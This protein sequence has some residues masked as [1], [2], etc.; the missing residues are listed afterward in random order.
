MISTV[1]QQRRLFRRFGWSWTVLAMFIAGCSLIGGQDFLPQPSGEAGRDT[2][3]SPDLPSATPTSFP[4][5][6]APPRVLTVCLANE[7]ETLY[8]YGGAS[9]A[10]K[11][12]LEAI[13]DGP[14]D[15]VGYQF[16]PVILEQLPN[17]ADGNAALEPSPVKAG[18]WVV[19]DAGE[20]VQLVPGEV[21]RPSGCAAP[22]CAVAWDGNPLVMD[23]LSATFTIKEGILWSDGAPLTAADSVFSYELARQCRIEGRPCGGLGLVTQDHGTVERTASYTALDDRRVQWTG[24]PGFRDPNY[25]VNFFT[26]LPAHLLGAQPPETLLIG[27]TSARLPPGWGPYLVEN[28][29]PGEAIRLRSNPLYFRA[30]EGLPAFDILILRFFSGQTEP[31]ENAVL[32]GSCDLLDQAAG[33]TFLVEDPARLLDLDQA[34]SIRAHFAAGPVW[35]QADFGLRPASYDDGYQPATDRPDLFGDP[36]T[37]QGIA[38]CMDRQRITTEV[39]N[40]IASVPAS[41]YP[42]GHPLLNPD[43]PVILHDPAAGADLLAQAGWIDADGDPTTPRTA[44]GVAGVPDG[45]LLAFSYLVSDAIQ[46]LAAATILTESLAECGVAVDLQSG[47][48]GEVYA[49]GPD[50]PVF[51]RR[52]DMAQFAWE[53]SIQSACYLWSSQQIPGDPNLT[54]EDGRALFPFGWGGANASGF[55]DPEFDRACRASRE[56]LPGEP[57]YV[58]THHRAQELFAAALPAIPLYEHLRVVVSRPDLCNFTFDPSSLSE[59][60]NIEELDFREE[61]RE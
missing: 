41:F 37:R 33:Q 21:I 40:G 57:G 47:P 51:G 28:W 48:A 1:S 39:L 5:P 59:F 18:D 36:R 54:A 6:T 38:L 44:L 58:E 42:P 34:G 55:A 24:V 3:L 8:L 9:L 50:G 2:P 11:Q 4:T 31:L 17:L 22:E 46:R 12:V 60:W 23:R 26:P 10:Q 13:Y 56:A 45:T 30:G 14:I 27:E 61:C 52:F 35:E 16:Q 7:P 29:V 20:L 43:L 53:S 15:R 32:S 49:P 19:N 25:P